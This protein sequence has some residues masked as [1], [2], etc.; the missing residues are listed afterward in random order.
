MS[1]D[2]RRRADAE[3]N[4]EAILDAALDCFSEQPDVSMT[5]IAQAAG[6]SRVTLYT[7][8]PSREELLARV[9]DRAVS[10]AAVV[11][12]A[13]AL[14]DGPAVEALSRLIRSAWHILAG[15]RNLMTAAGAVFSARQVRGYHKVVLQRVERLI[16]RGRDEGSFRTD[17]PQA[18]LVTVFY[19]LIH[20][21]A[22]EVGAGRLKQ[23]DAANVLE[24]T[25]LGALTSPAPVGRIGR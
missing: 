9:L 10:S 4:I 18:W 20:V 12:D 19:S 1:R 17:L 22:D 14:D 8:F 2:G 6:V 25:V 15:Y 3:R 16:A 7:H 5:A 21:A 11:L 23:R 24:A 13:E